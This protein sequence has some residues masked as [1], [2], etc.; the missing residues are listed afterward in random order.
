MGVRIVGIFPDR[1]IRTDKNSLLSGSSIR[2][3][4]LVCKGKS[5]PTCWGIGL[6]GGGG[7]CEGCQARGGGA[8]QRLK[9]LRVVCVLAKFG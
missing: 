1:L 8:S 6:S 5:V 3:K 9:C 7:D 4:A 2:V